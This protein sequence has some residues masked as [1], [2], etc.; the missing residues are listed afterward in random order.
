MYADLSN[1]HHTENNHY[2][3]TEVA[4]GFSTQHRVRAD[5]VI[6]KESLGYA[7]FPALE[8]VGTHHDLE[9]FIREVESKANH[10]TWKEGVKTDDR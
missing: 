9:S 3:A 2:Y 7:E 10:V 6:K 5:L 8:K 1:T 4:D